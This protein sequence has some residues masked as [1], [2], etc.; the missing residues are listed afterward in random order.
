MPDTAYGGADRVEMRSMKGGLTNTEHVLRGRRYH[1]FLLVAG[2]GHLIADDGDQP[3][4]APCFA[5]LPHGRART[6]SLD[7]GTRGSALG[8]PDSQLGRAIPAGATG[9]HIREIIGR[10]MVVRDPDPTRFRRLAGLV[11]AVGRE[12]YEND[13]AAESVVHHSLALALIEVWRLSRPEIAAPGP[14]PRNIVHTFLSLVDLHLRDQW[15]VQRYARQIG[16]S[17]DR[18]NSAVRRATGRS[19]LAHIHNRLMAE[20]KGLLAGSSLQAAEVAYKLG[21]GDAAYFNRFFQRHAGMPPGRYRRAATAPAD[22]RDA[23]FAA[24][25]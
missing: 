11:E 21:F 2:A 14:L 19:P 25:P 15:T 5:W 18:L 24:W 23:S 22:D 7:A 12:L 20:A 17:R 16:V 13:A 4:A 9:T 3:L 6:V 1:L 8:I 10:P